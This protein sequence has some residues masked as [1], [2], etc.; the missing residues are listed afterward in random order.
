MEECPFRKWLGGMLCV[1]GRRNGTVIHD[2]SW[3]I[4]VDWRPVGS[5]C[6]G[7][8]S[9]GRRPREGNRRKAISRAGRAEGVLRRPETGFLADPCRLAARLLTFLRMSAQRSGH[10]RPPPRHP[11]IVVRNALV[12]RTVSSPHPAWRPPSPPRGR[13]IRQSPA[14]LGTR[15][16][17]PTVLTSRP[18]R[19]QSPAPLSPALPSRPPAAGVPLF[20]EPPAT[21]L[22]PFRAATLRPNA[23]R[24]GHVEFLVLGRRWF[25]ML[26]N[27][28]CPVF[29][30]TNQ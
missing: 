9:S 8:I 30:L 23:V 13:R 14:R 2:G 28:S 26:P 12:V 11:G 19:A 20:A 5:G 6:C 29:G 16:A 7:Q 4:Q 1:G 15:P 21:L 22:R 10:G 24:P 25:W 3:P 18:R 27:G 17:R